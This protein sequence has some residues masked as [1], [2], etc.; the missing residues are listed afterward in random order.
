MKVIVIGSGLIGVSTAYALRRF[1]HAVTVIDRQEGPGRE[2]SF[3]NGSL[4]TPS[5]PEPWNAPGCWRVLLASVGRS[6]SPLQLR[7]RA[8]PS[9]AGWGF[10]FLRNSAPANFER[11]TLK[12]LRLA[13]YSLKVME[14]LRQET[15][16]EYGRSAAGTLRVF[17]DVAALERSIAAAYRLSSE[18]VTFRKLSSAETAE[19]EPALAPIAGS[20]AGSIHSDIDETGN[21]HRFCAALSE[22]A[23]A[24]GVEFRFGTNVHSLQ[25]RSGE[26]SAVQSSDGNLI[27][28]RYIVAAGS[29]STPLLRR[30]GVALPVRPAKGYSVT[31]DRPLDEPSLRI[32]VVD[33]DLHAVIVPLEGMIRVAGTAEF[34][35]YDL[36]LPAARIRNLLRLPQRV[37]PQAALDSATARPWCGL[38][39]MS[40][41]GVPII[42]GTAVPNLLVNT[43]HGHLG[44]T[45]SAGSG[46]LLADLMSGASPA[47]D[48][49]A[50]AL[51]RFATARP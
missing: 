45:M 39:P 8:L 47:I 48:P 21:A 40:A 20:L 7:V 23:R 4:L 13:A 12:N 42:G 46:Q 41:D 3:A 19:L 18:G 51:S 33:D 35:G 24:A 43:G 2:T 17:R 27:A 31:F 1:G 11:N 10:T 37:L 26:V 16:V 29:Y 15:G 5:M 36:T 49:D 28:D 22:R 34:T 9:L 44:W 14:S 32:P 38:R 50:Y 6:D 25:M 30:I